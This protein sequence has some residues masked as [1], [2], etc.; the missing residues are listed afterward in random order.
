[1]MNNFERNVGMKCNVDDNGKLHCEDGPAL[2]TDNFYDYFYHGKFVTN[3]VEEWLYERN[4][5]PDKMTDEDKLALS[6][7]MRSLV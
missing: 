4:I 3:E 1:M 6:F 7:Y 5:D 2:F